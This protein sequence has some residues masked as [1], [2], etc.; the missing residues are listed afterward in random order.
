MD[1]IIMKKYNI[2]FSFSILLVA[3]LMLGLFM[4]MLLI[5][6]CFAIHELGHL[7]FIKIFKYRFSNFSLYPYGGVI[8][9]QE[10]INKHK[11]DYQVSM[12][13]SSAS[14]FLCVKNGW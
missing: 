9:Y 3:S 5:L 12:G 14:K 8:S 1:F 6:I 13:N 11:N 4:N 7:F 10:K 2:H